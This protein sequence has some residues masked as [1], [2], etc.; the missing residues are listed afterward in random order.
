MFQADAKRMSLMRQKERILHISVVLNNPIF[1]NEQ[2]PISLKA[3]SEAPAQIKDLKNLK[4]SSK[5]FS[6]PNDISH[7]HDC[8]NRQLQKHLQR[9][10]PSRLVLPFG[11]LDH[12]R[13]S[14]DKFCLQGL[15]RC[16]LEVGTCS[17]LGPP[18]W[19]VKR[20]S[21]KKLSSPLIHPFSDLLSFPAFFHIL[22]LHSALPCLSLLPQ[23]PTCVGRSLQI[24]WHA[25]QVSDLPARLLAL[26][27][28]VCCRRVLATAIRQS[29]CAEYSYKS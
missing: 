27:N 22:P 29:M 10:N 26:H 9:P 1:Q 20:G 28:S 2:L 23:H 8:D 15:A 13:N 7:I 25:G 24:C 6:K 11:S 17:V 16:Q 4:V 3:N 14:H 5:R 18:K 19:S 21:Q 12:L